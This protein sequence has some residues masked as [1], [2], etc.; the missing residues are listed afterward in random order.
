MSSWRTTPLLAALALAAALALP[1]AGPSAVTP[2]AGPSSAYAG[3][4]GVLPNFEADGSNLIRLLAGAFDPLS[5]PLPTGGI[6]LVSRAELP[7]G[8]AQYWLVQVSGSRF[9]DAQAAIKAS[10]G[11]VAGYVPDNTYMV[12]ATPAEARDIAASSAV[13]WLGYYQPAWRMP[14]AANGRPGL[15]ELTGTRVYRVSVF[16]VEPNPRVVGQS[17]DGLT[18]VRVLEDAGTVVDVVATAAQVAAIA[19]IP[20]VEWVSI[21]PAPV[22]MNANARWVNDTGVRDLYAA[23]A[24]GRL[25]GAGQTAAVADTAINYTYDVN[26]KAH[27]AFRDCDAGGACKQAIYTQVTPGTALANMTTIRNNATAHRKMV[28]FFDLGDTGPNMYDPSSH[29]THVAGSVD[30]DRGGDG[31]WQ[32]HDGLAPGAMHVHQNIGSGS[33]GL[34]IPADVYQLFRQA[35]RPRAPGAVATTSGAT[36]NPADYTTNYVPLED[37]RTHNNSWGLVAPVVD[38]GRAQAVDRFVWDHEDMT[39]VA[40]AGNGGPGAGT[41]LSPSL[42]KSTL[43]SGAS[44]NGRQPMVSIDSMASFSSH[45]PTGDQ[46][47]RPDLATPGQIVVSSKGGT[48]DGYHVAQ[49]TSMSGPVLTGLAT[50]VRQYYFDGY[51][52]AGGDGFA[53][54]AADLSRRHNPSAALIKAT[55]VNGAERMR[56]FYTGDDGQVRALDGQW[57]SHG[58]GFGRV[59]LDNSLYFSGDATNNWYHDAYRADGEAFAAGGANQVRTYSLP[60]AA[61]APL[62]VTLAW[63]DAPSLHPAGTPSLVNNLDLVVVAPNGEQYVGN[64]MN[65]RATPGVDVAETLANPDVRDVRNPVERVRITAPVTGTYEIRVETA[66]VPVGRQGFA[67]AAS[68]RLGDVQLGAPRQQ[69]ADG[70]PSIADARVEAAS[71]DT[72]RVFFTTGEPTTATAAAGGHTYVDS[73]NAGTEGFVG[74]NEATVE[75]SAEYSNK[76]VVGTAHEIL[77]T[78]L[79]AGQSYSIELRA[80]DLA[81]NETTQTVSY[82][83]PAGVFQADAPDIGQLTN[84]G[85]PGSGWRTGTQLYAG[86]APPAAG[87][88]VGDIIGAFMFRVGGVD[89]A[90]II[91]AAVEL[92]SAHDWMIRYDQDPLLF[93]D[94]LDESV[95]EAWGTQTHGQI[96]GASAA[97]RVRPET[98]HLRGAY[99][100]YSFSFTCAELDDLRATLGNGKAAFRWDGTTVPATGVFSGDFGFNRRSAGPHLRPRLVLFTDDASG[101]PDGRPC[102]ASTPAPTITDLG[103]HDGTTE[104]TVTVSWE[105]DVDSTS[106]VLFREQGTSAWT[107]VGTPTLTKIHHVQV[108]G[109]DRTKRYEFVVRSAACNGATTTDT[110][111]GQG[112]HFFRPPVPEVRFFF[113]GEPTDQASK[114]LGTPTA[115]F[116]QTAPT[117]TVPA[118]QTAAWGAL[119]NQELAGNPLAAYWKGPFSGTLDTDVNLRWFWSTSPSRVAFGQSLIVSVFADPVGGSG[120]LI[121]R[122]TVGVVL[123][124][125]PT[126]NVATV[127]VTGTVQRELLIQVV[128]MFGV[129]SEALTTT[130]DSPSTPGSFG[131]LLGEPEKPRTG[132]KPPPSAGASGLTPPPT[133]QSATPADIAA[134]TAICGA[135]NLTPTDLTFSSQKVRGGD[136]V[137]F[138]ATV[139]NVGTASATAIAVRFTD[140]GTQIGADK[141]IAALA[142]G[143]SATVTSDAW[144]TKNVPAGDHTIAATVDPLDAIFESNEGDNTR[145]GTLTVQGNKVKNGSFETSTSGSAPDNWTSSGSTSYGSGG[146]D[147]ERGVTA[148]PGGTWTSDPIAVEAG[149]TYNLA[150]ASSGAVGTVAVQQLS[151][152]GAVLGTVTIP[153]LATGGAFAT[154]TTAVT[155]LTGASSVRI[156]LHGGLTGTT[157]FDDV[158]LFDE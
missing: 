8:V 154:V 4:G 142:P 50:L 87:A 96:V 138:S 25:T 111:G 104:G 108:L 2:D 100:T 139:K 95:E 152:A 124:P 128:P 153:T 78:G 109:L 129:A 106:V 110:N 92:T 19:A 26:G 136:Q 107:Q 155:G 94:L 15:L 20:A 62:D 39:I 86:N 35:Y 70:G 125:T 151:A 71:A 73:Y 130:Y 52:A 49:G 84:S 55:L 42:A 72:A 97:A 30:G 77:L 102:D 67:L 105:T 150:V 69:D 38:D 40:S 31:T 127:H 79:Q 1:G 3:S 134:G 53:A 5:Q 98:A 7:A 114:T 60:V 65:S 18:G 54:G 123:G 121:G 10:G 14:Q 59:N 89:P 126:L 158:R 82:T 57:P 113:K 88:P 143:A 112:Y 45:G 36:G 68:G 81:G 46:R 145:S 133:R 33:G 148:G 99:Q 90:R 85:V 43:S 24:P 66:A 120:T 115:T 47:Y 11:T 119:V 146:S 61:G 29:G 135:P 156:V 131:W 117:D 51:A 80:R 48:N 83:S 17:L 116:G 140:H 27:V 41:I 32:G 22:L 149:K 132:P 63:A 21:R 44:A 137:T 141:T 91:G 147:G 56:G 74:L 28:A 75:T 16:A 6:P 34:T 93:V 12:R 118:V 157:S 103:I 76:P 23:T 144:S 13:R 58:Q 64:N 9:G 101:Y 122:A 37:A